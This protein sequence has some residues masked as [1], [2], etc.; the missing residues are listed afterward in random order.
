MYEIIL[1]SQFLNQ[2]DSECPYRK[3]VTNGGP[4]TIQPRIPCEESLSERND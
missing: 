2:S 3:I 4:T 1:Y